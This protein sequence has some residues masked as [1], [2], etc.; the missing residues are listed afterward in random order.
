MVQRTCSLFP[1]ISGYPYVAEHIR[2]SYHLNHLVETNAPLTKIYETSLKLVKAANNVHQ[3]CRLGRVTIPK[4]RMPNKKRKPASAAAGTPSAP[5]KKPRA[6]DPVD[7]DP[8]TTV[9][10]A[11]AYKG[12][13][14]RSGRIA[15]KAQVPLPTVHEG[16]SFP[17][18]FVFD[19]LQRARHAFFLGYL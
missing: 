17:L 14:R 11:P 10:D 15:A 8:I 2:E 18:T 9:P 12:C 4:K 19:K 6:G 1:P 16:N 3:I 5:Q 7:G 13:E